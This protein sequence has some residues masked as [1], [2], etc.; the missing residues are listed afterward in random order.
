MAQ[1]ISKKTA[2]LLLGIKAIDLRPKKPFRFT[3]GILSP[4]YIDNRIVMSFP[5]VRNKIIGFYIKVIKEKIGLTKVNLLSGTAT[6]AIPQAAFIAQKLNLP[7]VYVRGTKKGHGKE[8]Q[9]EGVVKKGQK[10]I[11]IED[12]ISTGGSLVGNVKAIRAAKGIVKYAVVTTTYLMKSAAESF[13]KSKIRVLS[14]TDFKEIIE[15]AIKKGYLKEKDRD[16]VLKWAENPKNWGKK[17][18]FE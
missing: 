7:M 6:A 4:I 13:K 5:K 18:G 8:N 15:V 11:V 1:N 9:I 3:S 10:L 16:L 12:H 2:E 14:L 17:F